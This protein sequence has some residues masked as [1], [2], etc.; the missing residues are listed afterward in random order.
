[1]QYLCIFENC[2][3]TVHDL[4]DA[5]DIHI[6]SLA[7]CQ[8]TLKF[9]GRDNYFRAKKYAMEWSQIHRQRL[10]TIEGEM[11]GFY[12]PQDPLDIVNKI[13]VNN[14]MRFHPRTFLWHVAHIM[15]A[16]MVETARRKLVAA[17]SGL[18]QQ[19]TP[20]RVH[21]AL[22]LSGSMARAESLPAQRT[23]TDPLAEKGTYAS[24]HLSESDMARSCIEVP[25]V[26]I[27][28]K[29]HADPYTMHRKPC[30]LPRQSE[31][32]Q[33]MMGPMGTG[34]S[35]SHNPPH[36]TNQQSLNMPKNK[37]RQKGTDIHGR[38]IHPTGWIENAYRTVSGGMQRHG[39]GS[40]P[41]MPSAHF[42]TDSMGAGQLIG[43][44][45]HM[46]PPFVPGHPM[47]SPSVPGVLSMHP[48]LMQ[49]GGVPPHPTTVPAP[50]TMNHYHRYPS[51]GQG[52]SGLI[53]DVTNMSYPVEA[54]IPNTE[55]RRSSLR[56]SGQYQSNGGAL[57]DPYD[58]ARPSFSNH[59]APHSGKK[60][61]HNGFQNQPGRPRKPSMPIRP[62]PVQYGFEKAGNTYNHG[63]YGYGFIR[64]HSEDDPEITQDLEK[65]CHSHWIGP[66]NE[67]VK[68]VFIGDLPEDIQAA[69]IECL[70]KQRISVIPACVALPAPVGNRHQLRRHAFVT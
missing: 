11:E 51:Q 18:V 55:R 5:E 37:Y 26:H 53:T 4:W 65:G 60:Q 57:F 35:G 62:E 45:P 13:F 64:R 59:A 10:S 63:S 30:R 29:K 27:G 19:E 16:S 14:E 49:H 38:P 6:E 61:H 15:R 31:H 42:N 69:E 9:I 70:F 28:A 41:M 36:N 22:A 43:S 32:Q 25:T 24:S 1:M 68:E 46:V 52:P 54:P 21:R 17:Q 50:S 67:T 33:G 34:I 2:G 8:E 44:P 39:P 47:A 66:K 3:W 20:V 12:D 7:F 48:N 58:G 56:H 23:T 40:P